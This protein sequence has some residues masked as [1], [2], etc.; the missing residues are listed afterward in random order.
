MLVFKNLFSF[1]LTFFAYDWLL[2]N[3]IRPAFLA[4]GSIQMA[5]CALSVPMCR[6]PCLLPMMLRSSRS[7]DWKVDLFGK[8]NRS[9]FHQHD[10]LKILHLW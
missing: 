4:I 7:A 9:F 3:G 8:W 1:V 10:I 2:T 6:L 5:I